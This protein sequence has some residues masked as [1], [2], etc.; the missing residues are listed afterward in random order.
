MF[1]TVNG[2]IRF[3]KSEKIANYLSHIFA[4]LLTFVTV[5]SSL[6]NLFRFLPAPISK[7]EMLAQF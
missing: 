4:V 7:S 3:Q 6:L 2:G 1:K 5:P